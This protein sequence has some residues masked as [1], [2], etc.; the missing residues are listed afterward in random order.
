MADWLSFADVRDTL[1]VVA[2]VAAAAFSGWTVWHQRAQSRRRGL[3]FE[4]R[5]ETVNGQPDWRK[6]IV[7]I[8][9]HEPVAAIVTALSTRSPGT[10]LLAHEDAHQQLPL[11]RH[12]LRDPLPVEKAVRRLRAHWRIDPVEDRSP[13]AGTGAVRHVSVYVKGGPDPRR[14]RPE[15]RWADHRSS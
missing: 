6:M 3:V 5:F 14:I 2:A 9:N 15:W 12:Q 8:R 7:T 1:T 4:Y 10:W 11:P 13:V